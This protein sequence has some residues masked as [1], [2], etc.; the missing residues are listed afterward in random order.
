MTTAA[1][2]NIFVA[3]WNPE[4][5]LNSLAQAGLQEAIQGGGLVISAPVYAE[6]LAAPGSD[7]DVIKRFI[8]KTGIAV[9][10][11]MDELIWG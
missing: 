7:E 1:D 4:D 5:S 10:W 11:S 6:L 2:T 8:H 3:L 9:D